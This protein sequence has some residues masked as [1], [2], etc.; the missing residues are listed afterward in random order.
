MIK[1]QI[2]ENNVGIE[3]RQ[4]EILA[5][6]AEIKEDKAAAGGIN[7]FKRN[8]ANY[9]LT[10]GLLIVAILELVKHSH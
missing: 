1:T 6:L 3:R 10:A 4:N 5:E 2:E 9:L 7:S 8:A